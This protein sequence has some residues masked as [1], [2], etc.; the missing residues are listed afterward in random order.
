MSK[1]IIRPRTT[2]SRMAVRF[3]LMLFRPSL[4]CSISQPSGLLRTT[5]IIRPPMIEVSSGMTSTG[6]RPRAQTGTFQR[7]IQRATHAGQHAADDAAQEAV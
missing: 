3:S 4:S 5:I 6:I 2:P 1:A 7:E